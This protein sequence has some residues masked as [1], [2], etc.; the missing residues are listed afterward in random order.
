MLHEK[1]YRLIL[2]AILDGR[3]PPGRLLKEE[4]LS[5]W[6]GMSRTPIREA[7]ARLERDGFVVKRGRSYA[8]A[9]LSKEEVLEMYEVRI[10]LEMTSAKLAAL[11]AP[12]HVLDKLKEIVSAMSV[13]SSR[14]VSPDPLRLMALG[15]AF[16]EIISEGASNKFLRDGLANIRMRL[17]PARLQVFLDTSRRR[18]E[19]EEHRAVFEAIASRNQSD[20]EY[21]MELHE[22]NVL[23][24]L[25][26]NFAVMR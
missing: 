7:L 23:R 15:G 3:L 13:E 14:D 16:H 8:V 11:R 26:D 5:A 20:A 24:F 9:L 6:L 25:R 18:Q 17:T 21:Y 22:T 10:P 4:H 2:E 12:S 1:A 19:V